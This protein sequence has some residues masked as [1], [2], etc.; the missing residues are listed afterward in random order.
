MTEQTLE[1]PTVEDQQGPG[2]KY[3]ITQQ[4]LSDF[5]A[6][7]TAKPYLT[8]DEVFEKFPEF[9]NDPK[10]L[11]SALDYS[12][13]A[14]SG[15]YK[16]VEE[17]NSKF[18]EFDFTE[19]QKKNPVGNVSKTI[20]V[21]K[22]KFDPA[23]FMRQT[24]AAVLSNKPAQDNIPAK[25]APT[26]VEQRRRDNLQ[27]SVVTNQKAKPV[28]NSVT[29]PVAASGQQVSQPEEDGFDP[30]T[31]LTG[32]IKSAYPDI[33]PNEILSHKS[34]LEQFTQNKL[35]DID[36]QLDQLGHQH[37]QENAMNTLNNGANSDI[38]QSVKL[39]SV[40]PLVPEQKTK[41]GTQQKID[42]L[43]TEK[44]NYQK[45]I[46]YFGSIH[47]GLESGGNAEKAGLLL[48]QF[49]GDEQAYADERNKANGNDD[50]ETNY[51]NE[52]IGL[53]AIA[54]TLNA[55]YADDPDNPEYLKQKQELQ[56]QNA[57]LLD[58]YPEVKNRQ[59]SGLI[60]NWFYKDTP[61]WQ[62]LTG[63]YDEPTRD[64][65][66]KWAKE[67]GL[68]ENDVENIDLDKIPHPQSFSAGIVGA[69]NHGVVGLAES[70]LRAG[71]SLTGVDKDW[72]DYQ[73]NKVNKDIEDRYT[74]P[75]SYQFQG[76]P[77][78]IDADK[79]S[80]TFLENIPNPRAG[81]Y[82]TKMA[83]VGNG[84]GQGIGGLG[85]F[86]ASMK[87]VGTVA[88]KIAPEL[89]VTAQGKKML[90]DIS[91]MGAMFG[92][93]ED[94]YQQSKR[95]VGDAAEDEWK[96][97]LM[98]LAGVY[99][100]KR[101]FDFV[102][103]EKISNVLFND[104]KSKA[105]A[106]IGQSLKNIPSGLK[107]IDKSLFVPYLK[108]AAKVV[109]DA[110]EETA[111]INTAGTAAAIAH[112]I[113][114]SIVGEG[115]EES[116]QT[117][118]E[119]PEEIKGMWTGSIL[120]ML[121]PLGLAGVANVKSPSKLRNE[122]IYDAALNPK[123]Y[124]GKLFKMVD[125]GMISRDDAQGKTDVIKVSAKILKE[126]P[127]VNP[128]TGK[129]LT[130]DQSVAWVNN[131][132]QEYALEAKKS[133]IKD[134][135]VLSK[136]YD[137]KIKELQGQR[138]QILKPEIKIEPEIKPEANP[139]DKP[140]E[141]AKIESAVQDENSIKADKEYENQ[142]ENVNSQNESERNE[143][144]L[145]NRGTMEGSTLF[146][147]LEKPERREG[148]AKTIASTNKAGAI[149]TVRDADEREELESRGINPDYS[150]TEFRKKLREE[151]KKNG[152]WLEQSYLD[153][154]ELIHDRKKSD[155]SENDVYRNT[156][157]K[158]LTKLNNLSYVKGTENEHNLTAFID[159]LE[160]HNELFPNAAYTIKG[161]I[162]NKEGVPSTVLEQ[163]EIPAERNAT[164]QEIDTYLTNIGFKKD[165][166]RNWSNGHEVWGNTQYELFDARPANVLK[167]KDGNLYF[168]DA[169]P[170]TV[171]EARK[172]STGK[173]IEPH[174]EVSASKSVAQKEV[175][176]KHG[177]KPMEASI[178]HSLKDKD[179]NKEYR[180]AEG[181]KK[182]MYE[183]L[184]EKG[185]IEYAD[186]GL[187]Y[188]IS[189]K[190]N[191]FI[192][193][194]DARHE[195]RKNVK[196]GT[197]LFPEDA[198][199]PELQSIKKELKKSIDDNTIEHFEQRTDSE[200]EKSEPAIKDIES[201]A[202]GSDEAALNEAI[203]QAD[204]LL[205]RPA[206]DKPAAGKSEPEGDKGEQVNNDEIGKIAFAR[207]NSYDVFKIIHP[208]IS[209]D[210]YNKLRSSD[211]D[212][213]ISDLRKLGW[214]YLNS[215]QQ[216]ETA[217][218]EKF[219]DEIAGSKPTDT[220]RI[221]VS[222]I[223]GKPKHLSEILLDVSKSLKQ[224]IF[225]LKPGRRAAGV[226]SPGSGGIKI[227]FTG[228]LDVTAHEI[229][230]SIDD[231]FKILS[232]LRKNPDPTIEKELSKFSPF[233]SKPPKGYH[234]PESYVRA[235]GFAEWL[236]AF[237]VNP[238][239]TIK[240]APKIYELYQSKVS[241]P[242]KEALQNF[243]NDVRTWAG[244]TGRDMVLSNIQWEPQK[245]KGLLKE[246]FAHNDSDMFSISWA[247]KLAANWINPMKDFEKAFEYAK[248]IKGIDE[249]LPEKDPTILARLFLSVDRKFG[250]F[251]EHGLR[252]AKDELLKD[253][254]GKAKTFKWLI[255]PLDNTDM[256][257]I[258]KEMED[259]TSFMIAERT[260]EL[261][262]K[263]QRSSILTG[264]GG[265]IYKDV[266]VARKALEE[267]YNGNPNK[268][269]RIKEAAK[270][271][272]EFSNDVMSY[273]V[274][275]GRLSQEAFDQIKQNNLQY[276]ALHRI[277]EA[278][279][280]TEVQIFSG[281]NRKLSA[282]NEP[283][284][285]IKGSTK[286]IMNPYTS[287]LDSMYKSI[288]ESDRNEVL[289]AFRDM[290]VSQRGMY[291]AGTKKLSEVGII[292]KPGDKNTI[293]V[294]VDGK[295]E[296]WVLQE[297]VYKALKGLD[298]DGYKLPGVLRWH[299]KVLRNTT[300]KFPVFAIKNWI[301]D[302]QDRLIKSN[303]HSGVKDLFG[304][305]EHWRDVARKGGLNSG[306]YAKDKAHYYGL[307]E[308]AMDEIAKNQKT[309]FADPIKIKKLWHGYENILQASETSNRVAEYR[310]AFKQA[311]LKG[312]DDYNAGLYGAFKSRDLMDFAVAG[313]YMKVINQ[314]IPFANAAVQGLRSSVVRAIEN[315]AGFLLR[316][317]LY[318]ALPKVALWLWNHRDEDSA[319]EYENLPQYQRD[320][321]YNFKIGPNTWVSIPTP[322][323]LAMLG[324]GVDRG[325]SLINGFNDNAFKGYAGSIFQSISPID[326][327]VMGG[328]IQPAIEGI[329]NYDFFR[330]K[331]IIPLMK[332]S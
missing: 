311:K 190:G 121:V 226:Y 11:Q 172:N 321:F 111:K 108:T 61:G 171:E 211:V 310:A 35:L 42:D 53:Q 107:N 326:P 170:H 274:E 27:Q 167:G 301:R 82:N 128:E 229:G 48:R 214:D 258:K 6:T 23:T 31:F 247:D 278:E 20:S 164:Q 80:P 60:G 224:K 109:L 81:K 1:Y 200:I 218:T 270:R 143:T 284:K 149:D 197:D 2:P 51:N 185:F 147:P 330:G 306:Y 25:V 262:N 153:D 213:P 266:D 208:E 68:S 265:G 269:A 21:H 300:T 102:P 100:E 323:E 201:K 327:S 184:Y 69:L 19:S 194:V 155:T 116:R 8:Q 101:V 83:V 261:A 319:K 160:A 271:Y 244:V 254:T 163:A 221:S 309:I 95:I 103:A 148:V 87:G 272:R 78:I 43:Q 205:Q 158:T 165:G 303:D 294:F 275:K 28:I 299:A 313:H 282:V 267:F 138:E 191:D 131:R 250:E 243:S 90:H 136:F 187:D 146:S 264:I 32:Q 76:A 3:K 196:A 228:D 34:T 58:K 314:M 41:S 86:V 36:K 290:T 276:V 141:P 283:I 84:L 328:P 260:V 223:I 75:E 54:T 12:A 235:E 130:H 259:V 202:A 162:D 207:N 315:P 322:Y 52:K 252:N 49:S 119:V 177:L 97:H 154:K 96:R 91:M 298:N 169:I 104:A 220:G 64:D 159:R 14:Q 24:R 152:V 94:G 212:I 246:I 241:D 179:V 10:L 157:G 287:L 89:L 242:Y 62:V 292:A 291:D 178:L 305:K 237:I 231:N 173:E 140:N 30:N 263:F 232:D 13:T 77:T 151:A 215:H 209:V 124:T 296:K 39:S 188:Q 277:M 318:S 240:Q 73:F 293:I 189:E 118:D 324:A 175:A 135:K 113:A 234:D 233:G 168:I 37:I 56:Q 222:P 331:N 210:D 248:G 329:T 47:A 183:K 166:T 239:E 285:E 217:S 316:M 297:D 273:M 22:G 105:V 129:D 71:G 7:I 150:K 92:G 193:A 63:T 59:I 192:E 115:N 66:K 17:L 286:K 280:G 225:F 45:A 304:D 279:P 251:L 256:A 85:W 79:S 132:L 203:K 176:E 110:T 38:S 204:E 320:M 93:Y 55:Q 308:Q 219:Y 288:K 5:S 88:G 4:A 117:W 332:T 161:F 26:L 174:K 156:D 198:N 123:I 236:R 145:D 67:N 312:M 302:F 186:E 98:A 15:K 70:I 16:T 44:A 206:E 216:N 253:K 106:E 57:T 72:M 182:A 18:P 227:R 289:K 238:D 281:E 134:D 29:H 126:T 114:G 295:P 50:P 249:V 40:K 307:M 125:K 122:T 255:E 139:A 142:K 9:N 199:I 137:G 33:D 99:F 120:N 325:L 317:S 257:T 268:L 195:T 245:A 65:V 180:E 181:L 144:G 46:N 230:H 127:A 133:G 74:S 112:H